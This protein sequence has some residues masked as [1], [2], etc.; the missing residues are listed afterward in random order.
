M[1]RYQEPCGRLAAI[2]ETRTQ[3]PHRSRT[4]RNSEDTL[5]SRGDSEATLVEDKNMSSSDE[6]APIERK[7]SYGIGGAG[8][9][10]MTR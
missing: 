8:N 3:Q 2:S 6:G 1:L 10:R 9:I 7:I 4:S 5:I